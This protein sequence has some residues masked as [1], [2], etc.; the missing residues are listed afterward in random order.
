MFFGLDP[1]RTQRIDIQIHDVRRRRLQHDLVLVV[2]LKAVRVLA[3]ATILGAARGLNV[4]GI[5]GL[6]A[7][8]TQEGG[9]VEGARTDFDIVGLEQNAAVAVPEF[10]QTQND[11]LKG[12]HVVIR[13]E[14]GRRNRARLNPEPPIL[15]VFMPENSRIVRPGADLGGPVFAR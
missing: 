15:R 10:L 4:G 12:Q 11:V 14:C 9:G 1:Q 7:N 13:S 2:V 3:I 8:G 5:P 6:G